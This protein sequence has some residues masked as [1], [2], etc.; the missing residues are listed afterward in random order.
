MRAPPVLVAAMAQFP[1]EE[2]LHVHCLDALAA[3]V[4]AGSADAARFAEY[5]VAAAV[6]ASMHA[7]RASPA[8]LAHA[9]ALLR[10]ATRNSLLHTSPSPFNAFHACCFSPFC[11]HPTEKLRPAVAGDDALVGEL[12]RA[13]E[14]HATHRA[15]AAD[16]VA[17]FTALASTRLLPPPPHPFFP[18]ASPLTSLPPFADCTALVQHLGADDARRVPTIVATAHP[19]D[20]ELQAACKAY[21]R[22]LQSSSSCTLL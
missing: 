18:Q 22:A 16:C 19:G 9:T 2:S 13:L 8:V 12:L 10:H 14:T 3:L 11:V 15:I 20:E 17:V 21:V 6:A 4:R 1:A 7:F 5:R